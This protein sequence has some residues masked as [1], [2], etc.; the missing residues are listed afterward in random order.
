VNRKLVATIFTLTA[1][2]VAYA[3]EK[4]QKDQGS[5]RARFSWE[6]LDGGLDTT[7]L[8]RTIEGGGVGTIEPDSGTTAVWIGFDPDK[9]SAAAILQKLKDTRSYE[10]AKLTT[11]CACFKAPFGVVTATATCQGGKAAKKKGEL[12]VR[13]DGASGFT[14]DMDA[15]GKAHGRFKPGVLIKAP[16]EVDVD[17][18]VG[19]TDHAGA[20]ETYV[21]GLGVK[22]GGEDAVINVTVNLVVK[23]SKGKEELHAIELPVPLQAAAN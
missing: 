17:K 11:V 12:S 7:R 2:G 22:K 13:V 23:D 15:K 3:E 14:V 18:G 9:T 5:A 20:S 4:V 10:A 6:K 21:H 19:R 8:S 1:L 16:H